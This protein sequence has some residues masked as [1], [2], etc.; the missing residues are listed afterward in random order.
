MKR[1]PA[2]LLTAMCLLTA[3]GGGNDIPAAEERSAILSANSETVAQAAVDMDTGE[4]LGLGGCYKLRS[5]TAPLNAQ[6]VL[7]FDGEVYFTGGNTESLQDADSNVLY[8]AS[9]SILYACPGEDG[10]WVRDSIYVKDG[11]NYYVFSLISTDGE[12]LRSFEYMPDNPSNSN[13]NQ[14]II[15]DMAYSSGYLYLKIYRAYWNMYLFAVLDE[16]GNTVCTI[17][18]PEIS[19]SGYT[20]W[21]GED[22]GVYCVEETDTGNDIYTVDMDTE[23]VSYQFSTHSGDIHSGGNNYLFLLERTDGLY[24]ISY[25]GEE[26]PIVI[27]AEC[28][29]TP[30]STRNIVP[31]SDGTYYL[32]MGQG[33]YILTPTEPSEMKSKIH[34]TIASASQ[35]TASSL[36]S[37]CSKFNTLYSD[38]Y[39]QVIDYTD[40]G[41]YTTEQAIT[42]LN[43]EMMSGSTPDML[44]F[45][46]ISPDVYIA[47]GYLAD[48]TE[49]FDT[50]DEISLDDIAIADALSCNGSIY[51]MCKTFLLDTVGVP[52]SDFGDRTGWTLDEYLEIENSLPAGTDM[53]YN[54]TCERFLESV[55]ARYI[56]TAVDF[57]NGTCDFN[58]EEFISILEA[59]AK[60]NGKAA[61]GSQDT[62]SRD[63]S[64]AKGYDVIAAWVLPYNEQF[65]GYK[66]SWVGW[67]TVD[68][69][70]GTDA[71][72]STT[73]G[74]IAQSANK[75]ICWE[76]IKYMIKSVGDDSYDYFPTYLP[77]LES[78]LKNTVK[79]SE[80]LT[81][82][83]TEEDAERVMEL[84][85]QIKNVSIYNETILNIVME[86]S[87]AFFSGDKTAE[88]AAAL[89]QSRAGIYVAEQR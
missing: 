88:Q 58:N 53:M 82:Q 50:D 83:F 66:M 76:F 61:S 36:N 27:W 47:R 40:G 26:M 10:I 13:N 34:V 65:E 23:S 52:Y 19:T 33:A 9:G 75:D 41:A 60:V 5:T 7:V 87:G 14:D 30:P 85:S 32:L 21:T 55:A 31:L 25:G 81:T 84:I 38:Y 18:A 89:I 45:S 67:P 70:C 63:T 4:W 37:L 68:G 62:I 59:S 16:D 57:E 29:I 69:S 6:R 77:T 17:E 48:L 56:R 64:Y 22:G 2:L 86:E 39:F 42:R 24:E 15:S 80:L 35:Y 43:T 73:V 49:Y 11:D 51:Y 44:D 74:I 28:T 8:T 79:N 46:L 3:C 71:V 54:I 20:L 12:I 78:I 1:V 72:P